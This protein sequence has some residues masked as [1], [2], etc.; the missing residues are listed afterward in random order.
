MWV[1]HLKRFLKKGAPW[2]LPGIRR[3][4]G[5]D[6]TSAASRQGLRT[7]E[8]IL[9]VVLACLVGVFLF[10]LVVG[11]GRTVEATDVGTGAGG[12]VGSGE[13][14]PKPLAHYTRVIGQRT[15]FNASGTAAAAGQVVAAAEE[16]AE[17]LLG[18]LELIGVF[19]DEAPQAVVK[20]KD[21]E[22]TYSLSEGDTFRGMVVEKILK[23]KIILR[24]E[25]QV[26]E[27]VL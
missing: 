18:S 2:S 3:H 23:G 4:R 21:S 1:G 24:T 6:V 27:L 5:A 13:S 17:E 19:L 10:D 11:Y 25:D 26:F 20:D 8:P 15:L 14:S 16:A 7:I 12:P 22:K 9:I